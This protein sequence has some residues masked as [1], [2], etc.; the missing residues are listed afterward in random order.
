MQ[1]TGLIRRLMVSILVIL[2]SILNAIDGDQ[3]VHRS[4]EMDHS[5]DSTDK[6]VNHLVDEIIGQAFEAFTIYTGRDGAGL[7]PTF[8]LRPH[9]GHARRSFVVPLSA[10]SNVAVAEK[11][12]SLTTDDPRKNGLALMLD[13]GTRKSHS[14]AENSAFVTGFF[15]GIAEKKAFAQ[16]VADLYFV[17]KAMES[18]FTLTKNEQ[19]RALDYSELRRVPS[20]EQDMEYYYGPKWRDV[21][22]PSLA[23]AKYVARIEE[24]AHSKPELLIAHQYTRYLGDLFGGQMMG[25]MATKS[26]NLPEGKGIAFYRFEDIPSAKEFI[27]EWYSKLNKLDLTETEKEAI[28]DEANLVFRLNIELFDELDGNP[29]TPM[30]RLAVDALKEKLGLKR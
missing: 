29:I 1:S 14:V 13:D 16:L 12:A 15:R 22:K 17:Y 2:L 4:G 7:R 10:S 20:L 27:T 24:V 19:V 28:V 18:A 25:G 21:V 9:P 23:T 26:L 30:F 8:S 3:F 6:L 11:P 5:E